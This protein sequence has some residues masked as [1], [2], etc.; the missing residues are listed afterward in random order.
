[1]LLKATFTHSTYGQTQLE[2]LCTL[3]TSTTVMIHHLLT[4]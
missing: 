3:C 1:M 4:V 2:G